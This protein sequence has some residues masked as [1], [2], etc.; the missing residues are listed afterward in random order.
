[1]I[2]HRLF[3]LL[4]AAGAV[5]AQDFRATLQ[6]SVNDPQ[7][8]A[9]SGA[10]VMLRNTETAVE[11][12]ATTNEAGLYVFQF[13]PP[14]PYA[15]T[16]RA[17]GFR[18]SQQTGITLNLSQ[19]LREDVVLQLGDVA[20]TVNVS[21]SV[22]VVDA[23]STALGTAI[24]SEIK[25]NLPL[26]GRSSLF[27]FTLTPGVV[28]NRYGED[29]RP[30]D[31]ITNV[32][33]SANGAPVA[34]TDVFVDGAANTINV[35]RGVNISQWVPAV[36]SIAE[37]KLEVGTV[38][39][40]YGRS[41][42]SVT[43]I[44][45]KSGT[46]QFHG[47][48]YDFL[49]NSV[50]DAN[51]FFARGQGRPL[52]AFAA[53]TFGGAIGGPILIPKTYNGRNRSFWFLSHEGSREGNG[54]DRTNNTPTARMRNGDF[55]E[56]PQAIFDPFSVATV[57][58]APTRT[59][60]AGN[61]IPA[62]RI[63]PVARSVVRFFPEPNVAASAAQPW[64]RNFQLSA[65]WPRSYDMLV[66]K[67]DHQF[68]QRYNTF[69]RM[70]WGKALLV[71]P[72]DFDGIATDGRN[73]V[74]RPHS[75]FS[76]GNTF[77]LTPRTTFDARVGYA[78]AMER[79]RPWS[80][81]FDLNSLG[82][83]GS[84]SN[85]VQTRAFPIIRVAG[86]MGLAGSGYV[87]DP[88]NTYTLQT[89]VSH[90][91]G[92]HVIKTGADLRLLYG[93][94]FRNLSPS[95][96]FSF[97]NA[98]SNGPRADTPTANTGFPL[99]SM[100][101]GMPSGGS[102]DFNAGVS[103]LNRY[104][105]YFIQDDWRVNSKLT[106]NLGLRYEYEAPRTERYN[107]TTRGFDR[108]VQSPLRVPD[109]PLRGGLLYAG[110]GGV[111]RGIYDPDRNNFAPRI[112]LAYSLT[113]KT[114]VRLGYA[115]HYVPVVGSV[116]PVGYSQTTPMVT[117][118]DG[119]TPRDR[120]SNPF[121]GGLLAPVGNSQGLATLIGQNISFVDPSDRMPLLHTWNVNIQREIFSKSLLQIG[122]V[123]S[124]GVR[125][126]SEVSIGNN[127]VENINQIDPALLSQGRRLLEVVPNPLFGFV[128]SGP[129]AGRTV[130]RQQLLR[131]YPQYGNITRNLP[132]Y[133][134]TSYH[135]LQMKFEQRL[136][137]GLSTL[138]SYT[139]SKNLGDIGPVQN[140][141][142]RRV[143]RSPAAFDVPQRLTTT[144][145]WDV[146]VG[147]GRKFGN[148]MSRL[149]D[150]VIGGWTLSTFNTFQA[151]FP[152]SFG[153][154]QNTLFAAGSGAQRPNLIGNPW[155]GISGSINQRLDGY[156]NINAF[157]QPPDFTFGNVA[158]RAAWLRSPGMNNFN[159]TVTK[160]FAITERFKLNL[161]G[162]SFNLMN[163]AVFAGPNTTF[164]ALG[165][166]GRI[167]N[168]NNLNRQTEVVLKLLF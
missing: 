97:S 93:N 144:A 10:A 78:R 166:F 116:D 90:Q 23:D 125:V 163:H 12:T 42:G 161:R 148:G 126:T 168:Q 136:W 87:E 106:L 95:G 104:Y 115:L 44:V 153:T 39:A 77:L 61:V 140:Y 94:F 34:A 32:L 5:F 43:N 33:F 162:S 120:L 69:F 58:G 89:N 137:H 100:M 82:L 49:R 134:N 28:N 135:S 70:N 131:P 41:G 80:E 20:E 38:P 56:V 147:R 127:V 2:T 167:F 47:T 108:A 36:D 110:T 145:S 75:G 142:N 102:I 51:L 118:Q 83:P 22:A 40:E 79:N 15:L 130:Q 73:V 46:N 150:T 7:G 63:D 92:R 99:A 16:V 45:I 66:W 103:I 18:T 86:F 160:Q 9:V 98:W 29:T 121:P 129:F 64:V 30:N 154:N 6:G 21:A 152:L 59:P 84:Y 164:G 113:P 107:R 60:F 85:L 139:Y 71:F 26:K 88:G 151:G 65:K 101:L 14:G 158:P 8:A 132:A 105:G 27:M 24:R 72:H 157:A 37:F 149:T 55:S 91:R 143:E 128:T 48:A 67:I 54:L 50:L 124:R 112:G 53:N 74:N 4:A 19:T 25:D 11:R 111:P 1:V 3:T 96:S 57:G 146:P 52:A 13:L 76:W 81:G 109:L 17:T 123:G 156:F 122:Y 141:Y 68:S 159:L 165:A 31:T 119:I 155:S 133:G 62:S 117:S 138:V 114:I 35:N